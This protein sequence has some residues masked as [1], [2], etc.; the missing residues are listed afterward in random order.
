VEINIQMKKE[1]TPHYNEGDNKEIAFLFQEAGSYEKCLE[2]PV[3]GLTGVHLDIL[4]RKLIKNNDTL[5]TK[6][7]CSDDKYT[8][9]IL[10][11][12]NSETNEVSIELIREKMKD[13]KYC[14]IFGYKAKS[15]FR[16]A[17]SRKKYPIRIEV[18]HIG[19]RGLNLKYKKIKYPHLDN[20]FKKLD[21]VKKEIIAQIEE[22]TNASALKP[23]ARQQPKNKKHGGH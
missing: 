18:C 1:Q 3:A 5:I 11:A 20:Q 13:F 7:F 12:I 21:E 22:K 2:R 4:L 17:F 23:Q 10:N 15:A 6:L 19:L 16:K 9:T 14:V 8:Y